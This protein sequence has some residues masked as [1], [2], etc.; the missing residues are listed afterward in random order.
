MK[1]FIAVTE[2]KKFVEDIKDGEFFGLT[3][4]RVMPKCI[5]CDHAD[6]KYIGMTHCPVCGAELSF[7]RESICQKGVANPMNPADTPKGT[8]ESARKAME[9]NR[10]KYYDINVKD[11]AGN[12]IGG[13]RQTRIENIKVIHYR[14]DEYIVC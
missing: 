2:V 9:D 8:G 5:H 12:R 6:K 13:Y 10:L 1:K 3:F 14:G 11:K 7:T 4:E